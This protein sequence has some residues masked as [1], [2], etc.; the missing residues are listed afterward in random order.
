[1][2][3]D[4]LAK[5]F[6]RAPAAR[7]ST[8]LH[9]PDPSASGARQWKIR[10]RRWFPLPLESHD[11]ARAT[12]VDR[13]PESSRERTPSAN[14][15]SL[16]RSG[17]VPSRPSEGSPRPPHRLRPWTGRLRPKFAPPR[18]KAQASESRGRS[19]GS[20]LRTF[21]AGSWLLQ[22]DPLRMVGDTT[23][24]RPVPDRPERVVSSARGRELEP[25]LRLAC[26][27]RIAPA[28]LRGPPPG[29]LRGRSGACPRSCH[30]PASPRAG[31]RSL[32]RRI[33][34]SRMV[35]SLPPTTTS[36]ATPREVGSFMG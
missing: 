18:C 33:P 21:R 5:E 1:M 17:A 7:S 19:G 13:G 11:P 16:D 12:P 6:P 4:H 10:P 14:E 30:F 22:N 28:P 35:T 20:A 15:G 29:G 34:S 26:T 3:L 9:F 31:L 27:G 24:D 2:S 32:G 25:F 23:L 8:T 36:C